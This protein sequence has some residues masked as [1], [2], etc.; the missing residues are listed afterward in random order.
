M[1]TKE[2]STKLQ[3]KMRDRNYTEYK[4]IV[5][6]KYISIGFVIL[7]AVL[8][9]VD[10]VFPSFIQLLKNIDFFNNFLILFNTSSVLS[11]TL[12][13][14]VVSILSIFFAVYFIIIEIYRSRY[15]LDF[16]DRFFKE[17]LVTISFDFLCNIF[18]G[19]IIILINKDLILTKILYTIH[20]AYCLY[21]F[22]QTYKNYKIFNSAEI[23]RKYKNKIIN[24]IKNGKLESIKN[25]INELYAYSEESFSKNEIII[26]QYILDIYSEIITIFLE[27][28]AK[29]ILENK[30]NIKT[31][32]FIEEK[33]FKVILHQLKL[34][35]NYG[36]TN[37]IEYVFDSIEELF[38][39]CIKCDYVNTFN[40]Y[41]QL[42]DKFFAICIQKDNLTTASLIISLYGEI[43]KFI[44]SQNLRKEWL[45]IIRNKYNFYCFAVDIHLNEKILKHV[46][47]AYFSFMENCIKKEEFELYNDLFLDVKYLIF[48]S[49][50]KVSHNIFNFLKILFIIHTEKILSSN[51]IKLTKC[52]IEKIKDIGSF[53][54]D[55]NNKD[56]C[57]HISYIFDD[58][59]EKCDSNEIIEEVYKIKFKF[60]VRSIYFDDDLVP[61]FIPDYIKIIENE[62]KYNNIDNILTEFE[63]ILGRTLYSKKIN[64]IL[65]LLDIT[66][67]IISIFDKSKRQLQKKC[68]D[69]YSKAL[70]ICI[71]TKSTENFHIVLD[72]LSKLLIKLDKEDKISEQFGNQIIE[73]FTTNL[74][75]SMSLKHDD[76]SI[77]LIKELSKI[78]EKLD[79]FHKKKEL[80][81]C[82]VNELFQAGISAIENKMDNIIKNISNYLGWMAMYAIKIKN[83]DIFEEI[84]N[85]AINLINLSIEMEVDE[86]TIV[87]LGTLFIVIGGHTY[88]NQ[89]NVYMNSLISSIKRL[90]RKNF[91]IKS[92]KLRQF[93]GSIWDE[94]MDNK[95]S[96]YIN[97]FYYLLPLEAGE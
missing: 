72:H 93:E 39:N 16:I 97:K 91:L 23:I 75:Q 26:S 47:A 18:V 40:C 30:N 37:Y 21:L 14:I 76:F 53:A 15:P 87:F 90:K 51:N 36:A 68:F 33:L 85:N 73:A 5:G 78:P 66:D 92:K 31:I 41:S 70:Y 42:L 38:K 88:A 50:T 8:V 95:A 3:T 77:S 80:Y 7:F 83:L 22:I 89:N 49:L 44:L 25:C 94:Y 34:S 29:L 45:N 64:I 54:F 55:S 58:I 52:Y 79:F 4:Q 6:N 12:M 59:L 71:D 35:I 10:L 43:S 67:E 86:N 19:I 74:R 48:S 57:I 56:L 84:I 62:S 69:L 17:Y 13:P 28:K 60:T 65:Y 96:H 20:V 11:Q 32:E 46:F 82:I 81:S 61:L 1:Q 9:L 24:L 27:N 2:I 63:E